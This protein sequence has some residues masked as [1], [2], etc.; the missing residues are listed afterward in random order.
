MKRKIIALLSIIT[1]LWG[2]TGCGTTETTSS[3]KAETK[4]EAT[5]DAVTEESVS[6][7]DTE[8]VESTT[9]E[10]TEEEV[11]ETTETEEAESDVT[12]FM[13]TL[14]EVYES[15]DYVVIQ[16]EDYDYTT[17]PMG[18]D[19]HEIMFDWKNNIACAMSQD[20]LTYYDFNTNTAYMQ[21]EDSTGFYKSE[22]EDIKNYYM[23]LYDSV[24][25]FWMDVNTDSF[26]IYE[27][28]A[29]DALPYD[30]ITASNVYTSNDGERTYTYDYRC[31]ADTLLPYQVVVSDQATAASVTLEDGTTMEGYLYIE[32]E[33]FYTFQFLTE[34]SEEFATF[35]AAIQLPADDECITVVDEEVTE[36]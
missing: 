25:K 15:Q 4:E 30:T 8:E 34:E 20:L 6:E 9:I 19:Y 35:Q 3:T 18:E 31:Y 5:V 29:T 12:A 36:E 23:S 10:E 21:N 24:L 7:N 14:L 33:T 26:M 13:N 16:M 17:D 1:L 27:N 28:P 2:V 11:T 32:Y 22:S